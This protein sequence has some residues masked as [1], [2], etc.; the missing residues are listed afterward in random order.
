MI[1]MPSTMIPSAYARVCGEEGGGG[2]GEK[3]TGSKLSIECV[4]CPKDPEKEERNYGISVSGSISGC[5]S[6]GLTG[7]E[8]LG[9]RW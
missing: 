7:P 9:A 1:G 5:P 8:D 2:M 6:L 3:G 4:W